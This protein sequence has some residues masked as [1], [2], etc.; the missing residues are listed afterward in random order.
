MLIV[1]VRENTS[2]HDA[3]ITGLTEYGS[4][5]SRN[6]CRIDPVQIQ[7]PKH[8]RHNTTI[9]GMYCWTTRQILGATWSLIPCALR[10][11]GALTCSHSLLGEQLASCGKEVS[12][13]QK[14]REQ[15]TEND[16]KIKKNRTKPP[17]YTD[18][19]TVGG[20]DAVKK[21]VLLR[22]EGVPRVVVQP[23]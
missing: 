14:K 13:R 17:T 2:G 3:W 11:H 23:A 21:A 16:R 8:K 19:E 12:K 4:V 5:G 7:S 22:E 10:T 6:H 20:E 1:V 18:E 9:V 15:K